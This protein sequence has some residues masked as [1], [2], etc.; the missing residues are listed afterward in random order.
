MFGANRTTD[1]DVQVTQ[2]ANCT[3]LHN[4][5]EPTA[6]VKTYRVLSPTSGTPTPAHARGVVGEPT[7]SDSPLL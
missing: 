2:F 4:T 7:G 1:D 6:E 5:T 3:E